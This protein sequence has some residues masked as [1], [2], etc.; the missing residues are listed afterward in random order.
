MADLTKDERDTLLKDSEA[1]WKA[2]FKKGAN[3]PVDELR[4]KKQ[5]YDA[6]RNEYF[7]R[8]PKITIARCPFS[9]VLATAGLDI[10]GL[11]GPAW[12]VNSPVPPATGGDY[13][14]TY[15]GALH[16]HGNPPDGAAPG[17][18]DEILPGPEAPFVIPRVLKNPAVR[19]VM[20]SYDMD[21]FTI[22]FMTYFGKPPLTG[23]EL[24]QE[25][26]RTMFGYVDPNGRV[27]W[28]SATDTWDFDL[29]PWRQVPDKLYWIKPGDDKYKL[30]PASDPTFPFGKI[31]GVKVPRSIRQGKVTLKN[32]PD[33]E[34][35]SPGD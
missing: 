20:S 28:G 11:D 25:W 33:G 15:Q 7:A 6:L 1:I 34:P 26:L 35:I 13:I 22:Y 14:T 18:S 17:N 5:Q 19:C 9:G 23:L 16:L 30:L 2:L 32:L 3:L 4:A 31:D 10:Y 27:M 29:E 8:L 21:P 24:H 12:C